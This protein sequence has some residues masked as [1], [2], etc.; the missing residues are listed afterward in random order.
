MRVLILLGLS[1]F[2]GYLLSIFLFGG[3]EAL[4]DQIPPTI[5]I[6][7]K[8]RFIGKSPQVLR[9]SVED[10]F[11]LDKLTAR[12]TQQGRVIKTQSFKLKGKKHQI[13]FTI[14]PQK[15]ELRQ[16]AYN[17]KLLATDSSIRI[18]SASKELNFVV[19]FNR[20]RI[21]II[22][23]MHNVRKGGFELMFAQNLNDV[24]RHECVVVNEKFF[25]PALP[26]FKLGIKKNVKFSF[27]A[28]PA[29]NLTSLYYQSVARNFDPFNF[30]FPYLVLN[31]N[32]PKRFISPKTL[33]IVEEILNSFD[34]VNNKLLLPDCQP[35]EYEIDCHLD[36]PF[37]Q[38][39]AAS[40][41]LPYGTVADDG[42][43]NV[44]V[45]AD[46]YWLGSA[47]A[48]IYA[49]Q[50]GLL[51]LYQD[52]L[53]SLYHGC[54]FRTLV[55]PVSQLE[56]SVGSTVSKASLIGKALK[57]HSEYV[58]LAYSLWGVPINNRELQDSRWYSDHILSKIKFV[59]EL[60]QE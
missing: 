49:S 16:G 28:L 3:I 33:G 48:D 6:S 39:V 14:D 25:F 60:A 47:Q 37:L 44:L 54:G 57:I 21:S 27:F 2:L 17:L 19:D 18:N 56:V 26:A 7:P 40:Y 38:P 59:S 10:N 23:R 41:Y 42:L 52:K 36:S 50:S 53:L 30:K 34:R 4:F 55:Y 8:I 15:D 43:R 46:I 32:L 1:A 9:I 35:V 31:L 11:L 22:T 51:E 29:R 13:E 20:P 45:Q 5:E 58:G 12:L 24:S